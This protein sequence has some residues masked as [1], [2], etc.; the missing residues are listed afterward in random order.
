MP[1]DVQ[2]DE[3]TLQQSPADVSVADTLSDPTETES[4]AEPEATDAPEASHPL[5]PDGKRFKQV[6]AR[7]KDAEYKLQQE[8]EEKARLEGE[9]RAVREMAAAKP[10][11]EPARPARY[12]EAQLQQMVDEGKATLGQVL[13]YQR[14]TLQLDLDRKLDEKLKSTIESTRRTATVADQLEKYKQ[15]MPEIMQ[16]GTTERQAYERE[17]SFLSSLGED[18]QDLKTQLKAARAAHGDPETVAKRKQTMTQQG[19][20]D[21]MKD[22]PAA[23]KPVK[24]EKD[25]IKDLSPQQ[26]AHYQRMINLGHYKNGWKDVRE[27][28]AW[29]PP[30]QR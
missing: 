26:R 21:T 8:R 11:A 25:P 10:P 3:D 9:L 5:E 12:T 4:V 7:A 30:L 15:V 29:V 6:W 1:E 13:A 14:D 27:E 20:H 23:G 24:T 17:L 19:A 28:L 2:H 18:P 22:T 16:S